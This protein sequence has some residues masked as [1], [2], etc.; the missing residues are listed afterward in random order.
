MPAIQSCFIEPVWD[1]FAALL[2]SREDDHSLGCH[3]P[4]VADR[5]IFEKLLQVAVFG[6]AY[7]RIADRTCSATTLRRRRDEWI[8]LG[9]MD[10]V[11]HIAREGYDRI[12]GLQLQDV[13]VDGCITK[14][15]CGGEMA[16]PSPVDRAKQGTKR[17]TAVDGAGIP[18]GVLIAP[19]NRH[20]SPLLAPTL[21]TLSAFALPAGETTVHLDRGYD[22]L[23]TR[24]ELDRRGMA[25]CISKRGTPAPIQ[26]T[27][28]WVVERTN[29]WHNAFRKLAWCTERRGV[30]IRFYL[31]LANTI[32][33]VRRL[34]REAWKRYRWNTRP[35][36][37]P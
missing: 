13:I 35:R 18:L 27:T 21:D 5:L 29:A 11:E 20:D 32:I 9:V 7:W 22:S 34:V 26:A 31:A 33:I 23:I 12:I 3:R 30:V 10:H 37:C 2:P 28:R 8:A 25:A 24:A 6:C 4:R 14:A 1:Q 16:G 17:S 19:A 36:R 15:P